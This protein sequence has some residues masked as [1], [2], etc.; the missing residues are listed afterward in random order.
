MLQRADRVWITDIYPARE[1]PI[2]GVDGKWLADQISGANYAPALND[3]KVAL[4]NDLR[5]G[6]LLLVMGAGDIETVAS[7]I[8][9]MLREI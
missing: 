7:D 5:A 8:Y 2:A 9:Q 4:L 1:E 3:L 6:D